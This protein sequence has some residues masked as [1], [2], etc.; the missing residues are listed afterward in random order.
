MS[1]SRT[2]PFRGFD[3]NHLSKPR[4]MLFILV[5][6]KLESPDDTGREYSIPSAQAPF[7]PPPRHGSGDAAIPAAVQPSETAG[8]AAVFTVLDGT[9][10]IKS[11]L[12]FV[13]IPARDRVIQHGRLG[14]CRT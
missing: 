12:M 2:R 3:G 5:L 9:F 10:K 11:A 13:S 4:A 6:V 14:V 7:H 8:Q 1:G